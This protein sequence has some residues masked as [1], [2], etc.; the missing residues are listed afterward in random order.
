[1]DE[2]FTNLYAKRVENMEQSR[3]NCLQRSIVLIQKSNDDE[4]I[5]VHKWLVEMK[6]AQF[7]DNWK[8]LKNIEFNIES[9]KNEFKQMIEENDELELFTSSETEANPQKRLE[10]IKKTSKE[11]TS[12]S[13]LPASM[14]PDEYE[15]V[16][17]YVAE[18]PKVCWYQTEEFIVLNIEIG[19]I[20]TYNLKVSHRSL[21]FG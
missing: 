21:V 2:N 20:K 13:C 9:E 11:T 5:N 16:L 10:S 19:D 12:M 1:M 18:S 15:P 17:K 6:W 7:N 4:L 14:D 3:S 8:Y